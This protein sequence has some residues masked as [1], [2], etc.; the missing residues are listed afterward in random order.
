MFWYKGLIRKKCKNEINI[1]CNR[2]KIRKEKI[3]QCESFKWKRGK[4]E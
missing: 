4:E 3:F 2:S 1:Y